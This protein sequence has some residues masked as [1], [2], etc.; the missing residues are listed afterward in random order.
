MR[1]WVIEKGHFRPIKVSLL[2]DGQEVGST[3]TGHQR[4]DVFEAHGI[5]GAGFY[6]ALPP[7]SGN[8]QPEKLAVIA[9]GTLELPLVPGAARRE[10]DLRNSYDADD[11]FTLTNRMAGQGNVDPEMARFKLHSEQA[12]IQLPEVLTELRIKRNFRKYFDFKRALTSKGDAAHV[13]ALAPWMYHFDFKD[14][15]TSD[16]DYI[17]TSASEQMHDFRSDLITQTIKNLYGDTLREMTVLDIGCNCGI[18]SFDMASIGVKHVV[19]IDIFDRNIE[20]AEYLKSQL[21]YDNVEFRKGNLKD[22]RAEKFDIILNLG[23]MYHLSTPYEV[24]EMCH[25][26]TRE[27]CVVDTICHKDVFSGFFSTYKP[28]KATGIEGD[29]VFELQPTYRA[30]LDLILLVGFKRTIEIVSSDVA[31]MVLYNE[32]IRRCFFCFQSDTTPD[33]NAVK[34]LS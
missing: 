5:E 33:L 16:F 4:P 26:M 34:S 30:I 24:M 19:G 13:K 3:L 25:S 32:A 21:S 10:L 7:V 31:S 15:K 23:V 27:L 8:F 20:Q 2:Y 12:G 28:L 29:T 22:L 17:Y 9:D 14:C 18:F 6:F 1:G 11:A